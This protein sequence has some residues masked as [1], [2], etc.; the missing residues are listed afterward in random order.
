MTPPSHSD[1]KR[2]HRHVLIVLSLSLAACAAAPPLPTAGAGAGLVA[3]ETK[4][5]DATSL[6]LPP[7]ANG[8]DRAQWFALAQAGSPALAEMRARLSLAKAGVVTAGQ[9]PNPTLNLSGEY[10]AAAAGMPAW[11]LGVAVDFLLQASGTRDR[12]QAIAWLQTDIASAALGDQLWQLRMSTQNALLEAVA[13]ADEAQL[14]KRIIELHRQLLDVE[15]RRCAAGAGTSTDVLRAEAELSAAVQRR[16]QADQR[17]LAARQ[18]LATTIGLPLAAIA[19]APLQWP[20]WD[21]P[22]RLAADGV[23]LDREAALLERPQLLQ[24]LREIDIAE[25]VLQTEVARRWPDLRLSP[26]YTWDHGERKLQLGVGLSLPM[27][28][29]NE[30]P[31]AEALAQRELAARHLETVE[32]G[33]YAQIDSAERAW[34]AARERW[35]AALADRQRLARL[36]EVER[37]RLAEGE[38]D[39]PALL[40]A[41]ITAA[42]A[43]LLQQGAALDAQRDFAALEDACRTPL[44]GPPFD[45]R[46]A[47]AAASR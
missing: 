12:A 42:E 31:I 14:L 30:G 24:A 16:Q 3:F 15:R 27:F 26:G 9:R 7:M 36:A 5:L 29:R 47:L 18:R 25:L 20:D 17:V 28:N 38:S 10:L 40:S 2:L 43:E 32:A 33:L 1:R 21:R 19:D 22:D 37:R 8:W 11:L 41:E 45:A 35:Q 46:A 13:A 44:A 23:R 6:G 39:R 34:P 4:R